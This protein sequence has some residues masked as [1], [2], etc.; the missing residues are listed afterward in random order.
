[1]RAIKIN[2]VHG[3]I[4]TDIDIHNWLDTQIKNVCNGE[5]E[6][7]I[8]RVTMTRTTEQNALM[9]VWFTIIAQAWSEATGRTFT[10]QNVH[11][12]YCQLFLPQTIA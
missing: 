11:D 10:P 1:M 3:Y 7:S 8:K 6:I 4:N 9:W 5:Y 2:K 12:A